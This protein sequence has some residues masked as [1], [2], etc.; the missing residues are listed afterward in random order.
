VSLLLAASPLA[1]DG[2]IIPPIM[3]MEWQPD[4]VA[5]ADYY[6]A[7]EVIVCA[8][9]DDNAVTEDYYQTPVMLG[10][11]E[12]VPGIEPDDWFF[13]TAPPSQDDEWVRPFVVDA[14]PVEEE[15]APVFIS[16]PPSQDDEFVQPYMAD[17]GEEDQPDAD[18]LT[19]SPLDDAVVVDSEY[20][21]PF[22]DLADLPDPD[23]AEVLALGPLDDAPVA[24]AD[25]VFP[26]MFDA[27]IVE[28]EFDWFTSSAPLEDT[29][30][31]V[32][33]SPPA[34]QPFYG[35]GGGGGDMR[36]VP[37]TVPEFKLPPRRFGRESP[38]DKYDLP[39]KRDK[40]R[41]IRVKRGPL[42]GQK[43][44]FNDLNDDEDD[45]FIAVL[46]ALLEDLE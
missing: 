35:F 14:E 4:E 23:D 2:T 41:T 16:V 31:E 28:P 5:Q 45:T 1:D 22:I 42:Q 44:E 36:F 27:E 9:L 8:P 43:I 21:Q 20:V 15:D 3:L 18:V 11:D 30:A 19:Q 29:P 7:F 38:P 32:V 17:A 12:D 24:N 13:A 6:V 34:N 37:V 46:V 25:I 10:P 39:H 33:A 26:V 40:Q